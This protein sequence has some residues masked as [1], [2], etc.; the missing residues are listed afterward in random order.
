MN[1]DPKPNCRT[2]HRRTALRHALGL[3]ALLACIGVGIWLLELAGWTDFRQQWAETQGRW[4]GQEAMRKRVTPGMTH[5]EVT[6]HIGRGKKGMA[7]ILR[8]SSEGNVVEEYP[9]YG[10]IVVYHSTDGHNKNAWKV[11]A[12]KDLSQA[13]SNPIFDR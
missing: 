9:E 12:V 1:D 2:A 7:W 13:N 6:G 10:F 8:I 11:S 5:A 3:L 4:F